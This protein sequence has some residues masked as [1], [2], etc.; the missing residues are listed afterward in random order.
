MSGLRIL[1]VALLC[2]VL[3]GVGLAQEQAEPATL[4]PEASVIEDRMFG[5]ADIELSLS[6]G[7]PH[8][9]YTLSQ[10]NRLVLDFRDLDTA[11]IDP[12][13]LSR[14][15]RLKSLRFGP[16]RPGWS[17]LVAELARPMVVAQADMAIDEGSG[18]A[19]LRIRLE[20]ASQEDFDSRVGTFRDPAWDLPDTTASTA[21]RVQAGQ[22]PLRIVLD[23]GHGGLDPGAEADGTTE[24]R[25]MLTLAREVKDML[26]RAGGFEVF[27]TRDADIFV[28]LEAR[29]AKAHEI[30]ADVF[31]SLHADA[32]EEGVARGASVYTLSDKA[33]DAASAA[34][35]ERH[36]RDDLLSGLDLTGADDRV[37]NVLLDLARLDNSPRSKALS[38]H[39]V[40]GIRNAVGEVY[41]HPQ[42]Q[43][44]FSVLK[45]ADIP[46]VLIE[47]AFLS[48]A[49]ELRKLRDPGWRARMAT[50]I[51]DGL[52]AWAA[53]D[54][55][56]SRLR[57]R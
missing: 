35:A 56:T 43:A 19:R 2:A 22:G 38:G 37:A 6:R 32:L 30:G 12:E 33:S 34:L 49:G 42:R 57:R 23:P 53:E 31:I 17:R 48:T 41:K 45:A 21:D 25:L 51:R 55:A 29:V 40:Q 27:L 9:V 44:G 46:S 16:L 10:P 11:G 1:G 18:R 47:V 28:S 15:A 50:G 52:Q 13:A 3:S 20:N 39:L 14:S 8:Q 24:A 26:E 7:V 4:D 54:A 36:D 5:G